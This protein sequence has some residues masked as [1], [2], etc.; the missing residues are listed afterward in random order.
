MDRFSIASIN[1]HSPF[2][3]PGGIPNDEREGYGGDESGR[4]GRRER[5]Y[6]NLGALGISFSPGK[7]RRSFRYRGA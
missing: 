3:Y 6:R 5:T 2:H 4:I 1:D 7:D